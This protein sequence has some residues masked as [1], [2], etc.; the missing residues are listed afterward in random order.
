MVLG[1]A[2]VR[3]LEQTPLPWISGPR[4]GGAALPLWTAVQRA[5]C[6]SS[7]TI[8]GFIRGHDCSI[9]VQ[10][11]VEETMPRHTLRALESL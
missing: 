6:H 7:K 2:T 11:S 3:Q 10:V 1:P 5:A 4:I 8:D 9:N